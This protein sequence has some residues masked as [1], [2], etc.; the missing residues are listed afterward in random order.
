MQLL[1]TQKVNALIGRIQQLQ[2]G[3][4]PV[5]GKM[6][7]EE[8]MVHCAAGIQLAFGDFPSKVKMGSFRAAVIRLLFVELFP[9]PKSAPSPA[10]M[11]VNKKLKTRLSFDEG[12]THL[13]SQLQRLENVPDDIKLRPH[14]LFRQLSNRQWGKLAYKHLDHH[15]RQFSV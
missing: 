5:W 1:S 11:N 15:L 12:K 8:M 7:V 4:Q 6:N 10:E 14:P 3:T 13:I 9:I 2:P